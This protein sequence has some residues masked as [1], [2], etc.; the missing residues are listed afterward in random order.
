MA[1]F[2]LED[3][4]GSSCPRPKR[5][6][7]SS[8]SSPHPEFTREEII[9]EEEES[10]DDEEEDEDTSDESEEEEDEEEQQVV[11]IARPRPPPAQQQQPPAQQPPR[12]QEYN[13]MAILGLQQPRPRLIEGSFILGP[14]LVRPSRNGA[15]CVILSD[16]EV[17]DC[18]ICCETLSIPVF[19]CENGHTACSSCSE[20]LLHKCPSCAMPIGYNR[21]R[22]IEKVLESLKTQCSNWRYG[23]K[24]DICFSKKYEHDKSCSHAPCTCPLSGCNFQGSSKQLYVHCRSKHLGELR[25]FQFNAIFPLFFTVN[26]KFRVLHEDKEGVLFILNN[27]S[28]FLGNVI[29]VSCMGPSSSKQGYFYE[30]TAK[31]EGSSIRFQSSTRN[32]QTRVDHPP[33]LGFL[34]VP[35]DFVGTYGQITLDICIWR[36]G[37][38]PAISSV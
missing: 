19:Q 32:V 8:P 37:S 18:P 26:D 11:E 12:Q 15:I 3:G 17:L 28:D 7:S 24:E 31:A 9:C 38:R 2:S 23:C 29:T 16:P 10:D 5:Q 36:L 27:R 35:N 21:C 20:K 25:G 33:S 4:E 6:R 14:N 13:Q 30:L 22:A 34:L 1:K